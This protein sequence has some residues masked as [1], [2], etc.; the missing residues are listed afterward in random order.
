MSAGWAYVRDAVLILAV[1]GGV[2]F[3]LI[4]IYAEAISR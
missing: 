3:A 2:T 4:A 1:V